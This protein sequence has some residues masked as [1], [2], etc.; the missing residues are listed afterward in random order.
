MLGRE[1]SARATSVLDHC[2]AL[3][4]T[5][6]FPGMLSK[7][8]R[9]GNGMKLPLNVSKSQL[10]AWVTHANQSLGEEEYSEG[11]HMNSKARVE[12]ETVFLQ[13]II[14]YKYPLYTLNIVLHVHICSK[15]IIQAYGI[16]NTM[17]FIIRNLLNFKISI[18]DN[19][20]SHSMFEFYCSF[21][22]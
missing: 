17:F 1:P 12:L 2:L 22:I 18:V 20:S 15:K 16:E 4:F 6:P 11:P 8:T 10:S 7:Q 14:P 3:L 5:F 19:I 21:Y 9:L 13:T